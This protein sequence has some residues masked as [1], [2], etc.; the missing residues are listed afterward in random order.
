ML[1]TIILVLLTLSIL[2]NTF[3]IRTIRKGDKNILI[4]SSLKIDGQDFKGEQP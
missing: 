2:L 3:L 1:E 4:F